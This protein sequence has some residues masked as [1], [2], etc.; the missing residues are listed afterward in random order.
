MDALQQNVIIDFAVNNLRIIYNIIAFSVCY[1]NVFSATKS[2][3][4]A[5]SPQFFNFIKEAGGASFG[6]W[7]LVAIFSGYSGAH[8]AVVAF[9]P[10]LAGSAAALFY[11]LIGRRLFTAYRTAVAARQ[12]PH[13]PTKAETPPDHP[14]QDDLD[15]K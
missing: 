15:Y 7:I 2:G 12:T 8:S 4:W 10:I 6:I 5:G 13:G 3:F 11:V 9:T 1:G 14:A